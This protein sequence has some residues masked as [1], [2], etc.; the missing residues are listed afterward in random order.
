MDPEV[1]KEFL[2]GEHCLFGG[3]GWWKYEF[4]YGKII[5]HAHVEQVLRESTL[6]VPLS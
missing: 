4:C 5:V 3:T 6:Y 2:R 1:V